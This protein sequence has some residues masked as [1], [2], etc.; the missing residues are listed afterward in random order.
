MR[1]SLEELASGS[2]PKG[3]V[4]DGGLCGREGSSNGSGTSPAR[5]GVSV[6]AVRP[7][8]ASTTNR[9]CPAAS[10]TAMR[11]PGCR[12]ID[13]SKRPLSVLAALC[14]CMTARRSPL[15]LRLTA[16]SASSVDQLAWVSNAGGATTRASAMASP[17]GQMPQA[18]ATNAVGLCADISTTQEIVPRY[19]PKISSQEI[20]GG[21]GS[22]RGLRARGP[23]ALERFRSPPRPETR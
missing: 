21:G 1:G 2:Q 22:S 15:R 10:R 13:N 6:T 11:S 20:V 7:L 8:R 12:P 17:V 14:W 19:R 5:A 16:C 4:G 23:T 9:N 3:T 18:A